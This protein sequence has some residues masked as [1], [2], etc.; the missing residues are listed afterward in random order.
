MLFEGLSRFCLASAAML[1]LCT[2]SALASPSRKPVSADWELIARSDVIAVAKLNVPLNPLDASLAQ[3]QYDYINLEVNMKQSIKGTPHQA[4]LIRY[5]TEPSRWQPQASLLKK[6]N[7]KEVIVFLV[8]IDNPSVAGNY[9]AGATP[10]AIIPFNAKVLSGISKE[11]K[12]Q[13]K[14]V[15]QFDSEKLMIVQTTTSKARIRK[16]FDGLTEKQTQ[17]AAWEQLLKLPRQDA[18]LIIKVM[19]DQRFL[20]KD[21]AYVPTT[22]GFEATAQ[23]GPKRVVEAASLLVSYLTKTSSFRTIYNGGSERERLADVNGW[24]VWC[25]YHSELTNTFR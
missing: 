7:G 22:L 17:V 20:A 24:R 5:Y 9:F 2:T 25:A 21:Y 15:N 4:E 19:N 23:Y 18:P 11:V 14:I 3:K 10:F 13:R 1:L 16:L 12:Q 6:Y 8:H